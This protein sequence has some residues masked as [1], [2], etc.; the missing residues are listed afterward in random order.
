MTC[1]NPLSKVV[2]TLSLAGSLFCSSAVYAAEDLHQPAFNV[3]QQVLECIAKEYAYGNQVPQFLADIV[4]NKI[5]EH[6]TAAKLTLERLATRVGRGTLNNVPHLPPALAAWAAK[7]AA[8]INREGAEIII[9]TRSDVDSCTAPGLYVPGGVAGVGA[10]ALGTVG[11]INMTYVLIGGALVTAG[12][13]GG[14][15]NG[16]SSGDTGGNISP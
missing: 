10:G 8:H 11:T 4:Q 9:E 15:S 1:H 12:V 16:S 13:L 6:G 5:A 2:L 7:E 3:A 14:A